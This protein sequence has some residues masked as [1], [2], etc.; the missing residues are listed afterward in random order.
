MKTLRFLTLVSM[1]CWAA[2]GSAAGQV[3]SEA[4]EVGECLP[5]WPTGGAKVREFLEGY[6]ILFER[7][8]SIISSVD[9]RSVVV[10]T[11]AEN[12]DKIRVLIEASTPISGLNGLIEKHVKITHKPGTTEAELKEFFLVNPGLA[13]LKH[14]EGLT[15]EIERLKKEMVPPAKLLRLQ[16]KLDRTNDALTKAIEFQQAALT[17]IQNVLQTVA[18]TEDK[19][20]IGHKQP[21]K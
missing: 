20:I 7:T 17:A 5:S 12:H 1:F 11:T 16:E 9:S 10:T 6:G 3:K 15:V 2:L 18:A 8:D 13:L 21:A 14:R 4:Y 19:T